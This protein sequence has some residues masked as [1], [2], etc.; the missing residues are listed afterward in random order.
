[1]FMSLYLPEKDNITIPLVYK[2]C[3]EYPSLMKN[4]DTIRVLFRSSIQ[5][6]LKLNSLHWKFCFETTQTCR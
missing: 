3:F 2:L 5:V 4:I 1:M 6:L